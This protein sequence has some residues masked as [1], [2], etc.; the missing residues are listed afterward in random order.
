MLGKQSKRDIKG[1]I[2]RVALI[3]FCPKPK[4]LS[5]INGDHVQNEA[6]SGTE[7]E[8]DEEFID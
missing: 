1:R 7:T 3:L 5:N 8:D 2:R 6:E 4:G